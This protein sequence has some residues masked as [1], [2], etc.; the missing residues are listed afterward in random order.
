M[1]D[2]SFEDIAMWGR[3]QEGVHLAGYSFERGCRA[4]ETLLEGDRWKLGGRF[5][6]V[7]EFMDSIGLDKLRGTA[8]ERG[9]IA[10]RIREL[11]PKVSNRKIAKALGVGETTVRRDTAPNGAPAAKTTNENNPAFATTAPNG[12]PAISGAAAAKIAE[13]ASI[14]L[15]AAKI[16][17]AKREASRQAP[18]LLDGLEMRIGDCRKVLADIPDSSVPLVLTD[19]P[20]SD[21]AE[22]LY[23]WLAEWSARVLIPGGSLICCTGH[24]RLDRDMRN[25]GEH[26]R[27]WWELIMRRR[28]SGR[29]LPERPS[30]SPCA[31]D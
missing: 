3:L 9:R 17:Q 21:D 31:R 11:Q 8:V 27:Y 7:D 10:N 14:K 6:T 30:S 20:Y 22:P 24:S 12:A 25:F 19:P 1:S 13:R 29:G 23:Q 28:L 18:V 4:L 2:K 16:T 15:E 26:L 5:K